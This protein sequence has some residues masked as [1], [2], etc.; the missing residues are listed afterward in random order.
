MHFRKS[1]MSSDYLSVV[2]HVH[3]RAHTLSFY[4]SILDGALASTNNL[5]SFLFIPCF[6]AIDNRLVVQSTS[7]RENDTRPKVL[8]VKLFDETRATIQNIAKDVGR[9]E[10]QNWI[11]TRPTNHPFHHRKSL[12]RIE[13]FFQ[14]RALDPPGEPDP[15]V[16]TSRFK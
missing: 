3:T 4:F 6:F 2:I 15:R 16:T 13:S 1:T 8:I 14:S 5:P 12:N 10:I 9:I 7:R 11:F